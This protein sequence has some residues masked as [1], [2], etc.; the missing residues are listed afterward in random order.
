[1]I[2][3][4][5]EEAS[6]KATL[7]KVIRVHFPDAHEGVD[8][9][10]LTF[11]GKQ[12]LEARLVGSL[13]RWNYGDPHFI[14]LRDADSGNCH[15]IKAKLIELA[16]PAGKTITVR[17]VCRELESWFLGDEA[18]VKA[19]YPGAVISGQTAKF[20]DPDRLGN[21]SQELDKVT[22][23]RSKIGRASK[24]AAHL[25]PASNRS[26]SFRVTFKTLKAHLEAS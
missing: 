10:V 19:A 15:E 2:V 22:G 16:Q 11:E 8:W 9:L 12:D 23:D 3:L 20:R 7:Q 1:M 21:A 24:I 18:A 25:E 4:M 6:M 17:I 13:Q 14:V 26:N 5:T